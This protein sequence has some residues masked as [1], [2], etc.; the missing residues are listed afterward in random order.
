[1]I[2]VMLIFAVF[3][4]IISVVLGV[5]ITGKASWYMGGA[6]IELQQDL[7]RAADWIMRELR[8]AGSNSIVDVPPNDTG[9][10]SWQTDI[11]FYKPGGV[12][13]GYIT[14]DL[15][16]PIQY[17]LG[18]LNNTQLLRIVPN[19][20]QVL[21]NNIVSFQVRRYKSSPGILE[22]DLQGQKTAAGHP[23]S[24]TLTFELKLRN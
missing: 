16:T 19:D 9:D 21:A 12:V 6:H 23:I 3:T 4:L 11:T 8:E 22:F 5:L 18:G 20:Q 15:T 14:W 2:E 13:G 10:D 1:M 17:T 24:D 7:R